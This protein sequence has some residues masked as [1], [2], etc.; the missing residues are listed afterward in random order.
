MKNTKESLYLEELAYMRERAKLMAEEFPHLAGFLNTPHDPDVE[1]LLEGF[2]LLS[3][4]LR[5][6]IEDSYPEITHEMLGRI[7]V[8]PGYIRLTISTCSG[9]QII[10]Q[11]ELGHSGLTRVATKN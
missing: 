3:S 9:G 6:T 11:R 5:S 4:N 1:R 8:L 7:W 2:A 10:Q